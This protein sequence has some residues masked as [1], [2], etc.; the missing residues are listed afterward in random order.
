MEDKYRNMTWD[1]LM[2]VYP[3]IVAIDF[4]GTLVK[5]AGI[6]KPSEE[7][8]LMPYAREILLEL[9]HYGCK[10]I[11]WTCRENTNYGDHKDIA[12]KFLKENGVPFDYVNQND[13]NV[14]YW[15]CRKIFANIYI[16]DLNLGGFP[17]WKRAYEI[18]KEHPTFKRMVELK[19]RSLPNG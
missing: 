19:R 11:I 14:C 16:D 5:D 4:D 12:K 17:G 10:I 13:P 6:N 1:E 18:I 9:K 3:L 7:M 8:E 2:S 15:D